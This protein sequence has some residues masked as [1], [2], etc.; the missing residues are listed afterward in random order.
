MTIG[1]DRHATIQRV[2]LLIQRD[3]CFTIFGR[4]NSQRVTGDLLHVICMQR[5]AQINH[6]IIGD[7]HQR[8]D[9]PLANRSQTLR[10]PSGARPIRQP[11]ER[12]AS[13]PRTERGC[14]W[15]DGP[16]HWAVKRTFMRR[17]IN[18]L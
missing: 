6:H 12:R 13:H 1:D 17:K 3:Q 18:I 10:H 11:T 9:R 4:A 7:I 15:C 2:F 14:L 16:I 5:T 8:A